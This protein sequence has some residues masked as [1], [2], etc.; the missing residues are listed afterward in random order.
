MTVLLAVVTVGVA[1][2]FFRLAPLLGADLLPDRVVRLASYAG[3]AVLAG[4]A[5]RAV[6]LHDNPAVTAVPG[7]LL[8]VAA[9]APALYLAH[10]GRSMLLAIA[11]AAATYLVLT[12]ALGAGIPV[13]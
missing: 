11:T 13:A 10:H 12:T 8:A 7:P 9:L 3:L 4:L 6:V 1:S 5:T 2:L